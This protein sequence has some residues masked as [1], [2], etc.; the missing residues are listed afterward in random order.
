MTGWQRFRLRGLQLAL[1]VAVLQVLVPIWAFVSL[2]ATTD[3]SIPC[4]YHAPNSTPTAP[5]TPPAP[6][7]EACSLCA[8]CGVVT[9]FLAP[10]GP[11]LP[12]PPGSVILVRSATAPGLPHGAT[13]VYARARAPPSLSQTQIAAASPRFV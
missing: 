7:H 6:H 11:S 9:A 3:I 13:T 8:A 12:P 1:A 2:P 10:E 4:V 5:G